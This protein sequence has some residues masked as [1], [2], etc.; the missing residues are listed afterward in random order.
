MSAFERV[1]AKI[2]RP[3]L[4]DIEQWPTTKPS[5]TRAP[6]CKQRSRDLFP[7]LAI[8]VVE[9]AIAADARAIV[10][11]AAVNHGGVA[12]SF[13]IGCHRLRRKGAG[14]A[15]PRLHRI[16]D[17][18]VRVF[19]YQG[20]G[21]GRGLRQEEPVIRGARTIAIHPLELLDGRNDVEDRRSADALR[22]V[23]CESIGDARA[24]I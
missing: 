10:F 9:G 11:A 4:P 8:G 24:P 18:V 16:L 12:K 1:T 14:R 19:A 21:K 7:S 13:A 3:V 23:E 2:E 15:A 17:E 20:F 22:V 6:Q 5:A